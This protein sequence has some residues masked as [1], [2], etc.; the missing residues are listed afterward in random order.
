MTLVRK[1]IAATNRKRK[2]MKDARK[3]AQ[4]ACRQT[5]RELITS[6]RSYSLARPSCVASN[7]GES[8]IEDFCR[9]MDETLVRPA[10][11]ALFDLDE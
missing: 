3:A 5:S 7:G 9:M 11:L 2:A 6:A 4:K 8:N 10:D 1:C